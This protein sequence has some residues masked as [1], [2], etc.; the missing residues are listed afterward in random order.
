[1]GGAGLWDGAL[2][3]KTMWEVAASYITYRRMALQVTGT[4]QS[5][6]DFTPLKYKKVVGT[7]DAVLAERLVE[8][9]VVVE[10]TLCA[11]QTP[12]LT[13]SEANRVS[14]RNG[15]CQ[16]VERARRVRRSLHRASARCAWRR[17]V[18]SER[19]EVHHCDGIASAAT[20]VH[21]NRW[22]QHFEL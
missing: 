2:S 12:C 3:S 10:C 16:C 20:S 6:S 11:F 18:D 5:S 15:Q 1:M 9:S 21:S 8:N 4:R 17:C 19:I 13:Y 22:Y 7:V 14:T